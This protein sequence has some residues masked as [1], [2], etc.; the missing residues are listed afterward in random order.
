MG[1]HVHVNDVARAAEWV[2]HADGV[3]GGVFN[4]ADDG[5][6]CAGELIRRLVVPL[7]VKVMRGLP[8]AITPIFGWMKPLM[9]W[10][11]SRLN[12]KVQGLWK[13]IVGE[14][15]LVPGLDP[16][17]DVDWLDYIF[18]DH[19]YD[20]QRLKDLGFTYAHPDVREGLVETL[21]WYRETRWLP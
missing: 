4:V 2:S 20:N 10:Y 12:P 13:R 16:A 6:M 19:S 17:I 9:R 8:W 14:L 11:L 3:T 15:D 1:H 18:H 5:P 21:D 7:G